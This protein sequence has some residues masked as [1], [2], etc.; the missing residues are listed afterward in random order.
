MSRVSKRLSNRNENNE[1][2]HF[3]ANAMKLHKI[4][5]ELRYHDQA[6]KIEFEDLVQLFKSEK[7]K[8]MAKLTDALN[9]LQFQEN[10][11]IKKDQENIKLRKELDEKHLISDKNK[12][13]II[14]LNQNKIQLI[15]EIKKIRKENSREFDSKLNNINIQDKNLKTLKKELFMIINLFKFRLVNF[16]SWK[17]ENSFK[18]YLI[19]I[20]KNALKFLEVDKNEEEYLSGVKYWS[21]LRELLEGKKK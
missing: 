6:E 8:K 12:D 16:D 13:E 11:N 3:R 10:Q 21:H 15:E 7:E 20:D 2:F 4:D 18:G 1:F 17:E 19:D 14:Q 5:D 9:N